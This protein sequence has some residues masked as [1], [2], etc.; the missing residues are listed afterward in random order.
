MTVSFHPIAHIDTNGRYLAEGEGEALWMPHTRMTVKAETELTSGTYT[1][2]EFS[3]PPGYGPPL[4]VHQDED[5]AFYLIEGKMLMVCGDE[6]WHVEAGGF[7]F[8]PRQVPHA[9]VVTSPDPV[10]ALQLTNPAG[11]ERFA[12]EIGRPAA[13]PGLPEPIRPD[14]RRTAEIALRYGYKVI[15]P[16]LTPPER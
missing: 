2:I 8:L 16:A 12:A 9:F 7:V 6:R 15:G 5:E 4:H 3:T 1:L 14:A 13:G 10:R 11:F